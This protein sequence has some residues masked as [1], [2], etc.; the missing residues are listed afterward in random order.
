MRTEVE[1][2]EE[3]V[4]KMN[5]GDSYTLDSLASLHNAIGEMMV[6]RLIEI[7]KGKLNAA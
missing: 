5:S 4:H 7:A 3:V 1:F 2:I 6:D